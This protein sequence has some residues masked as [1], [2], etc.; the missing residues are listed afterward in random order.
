MT[1]RTI[2]FAAGLSLAAMPAV[3]QPA[4]PD[5]QQLNSRSA[6]YAH[7]NAQAR[8]QYEA[9]QQAYYAGLRQHRRAVDRTD[10]RYARQQTAYADAMAAWREQVRQCQKGHQ[11]ICKQ[12]APRVS[13][14]Y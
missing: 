11:R 4:G 5:T 8:V 12:P 1:F 3:A 9:D 6:T 10:A 13:D 7:L 14:Y 2:L